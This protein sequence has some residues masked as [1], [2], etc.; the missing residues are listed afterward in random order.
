MVETA[1]SRMT[2]PTLYWKH[3]P[4]DAPVV[5]SVEGVFYIPNHYRGK[6][7]EAYI[8][9]VFN[10]KCWAGRKFNNYLTSSKTTLT[11]SDIS[12]DETGK[13]ILLKHFL[14]GK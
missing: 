6:L 1:V 2:M 4:T 5:A 10:G 14:L 3:E 9:I 13:Q 7:S 12:D 8:C 11:C